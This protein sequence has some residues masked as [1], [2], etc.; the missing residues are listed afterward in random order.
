MCRPSTACDNKRDVL[1]RSSWAD[2]RK[3]TD[4]YDYD[5]TETAGEMKAKTLGRNMVLSF[6]DV[7]GL[8]A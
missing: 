3:A 8:Q 7:E 5:Y 4:R 6:V 1:Q 2:A